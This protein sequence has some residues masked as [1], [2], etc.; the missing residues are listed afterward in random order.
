MER[1]SSAD[2]TR[3]CHSRAANVRARRAAT[4]VASYREPFS[5][6]WL[7]GKPGEKLTDLW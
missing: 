6:G 5:F 2:Y 4:S 1:C 7:F 3:S